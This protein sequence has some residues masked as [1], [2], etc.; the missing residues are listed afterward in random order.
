M[1]TIELVNLKINQCRFKIAEIV[2]N[3]VLEYKSQSSHLRKALDATHLYG[4]KLSQQRCRMFQFK[5]VWG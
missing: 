1:V 4:R 3:V 2:M 5:K